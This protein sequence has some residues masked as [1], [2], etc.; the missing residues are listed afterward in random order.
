MRSLC[1]FAYTDPSQYEIA[2][3]AAPKVTLPNHVLIKVY[4]ASLNPVDVSGAAGMF[5]HIV[6][7]PYVFYCFSAV[8][9]AKSRDTDT[10]L[11]FPH[12]LGSDFSGVV[13]EVGSSVTK[14]KVGDEVF[15]CLTVLNKGTCFSAVDLGSFL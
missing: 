15:G 11:R 13:A 3:I 5:K 6:A 1:V 14:W 10:N 7:D 4:A 8:E 12:K 9:T 2:S